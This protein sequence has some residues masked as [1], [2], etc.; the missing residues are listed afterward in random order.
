MKHT[1][2]PRTDRCQKHLVKFDEEY[3]LHNIVGA[4]VTKVGAIRRA[5]ESSQPAELRQNRT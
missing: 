2:N 3:N 5:L 4:L 1:G